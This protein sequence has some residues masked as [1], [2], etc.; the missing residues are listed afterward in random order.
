LNERSSDNDAY[1]RGAFPAFMLTTMKDDPRYQP[2]SHAEQQHHRD[3]GSNAG[4]SEKRPFHL[5]GHA[6]I[7]NRRAQLADE[8]KK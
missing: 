3:P 2:S 6:G 1:I 5:T 7:F 8:Q 4:L